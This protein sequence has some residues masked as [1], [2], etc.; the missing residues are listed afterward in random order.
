MR[1][2]YSTPST[3]RGVN[4]VFTQGAVGA[5]P[6]FTVTYLILQQGR[7]NTTNSPQL[8]IQSRQCTFFHARHTNTPL[9]FYAAI[10]RSLGSDY[11]PSS[12]D[13]HDIRSLPFLRQSPYH[14]Q[15]CWMSILEGISTLDDMAIPAYDKWLLILLRI[16]LQDLTRTCSND[17]TV[18]AV[19]GLT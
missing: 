15:M 10:G 6:V 16:G 14:V 12:H 18:A 9:N 5:A 11:R 13:S 4:R 17:A 8:S 7:K 2:F 19:T 3:S 1:L